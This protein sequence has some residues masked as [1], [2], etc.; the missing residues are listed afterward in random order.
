MSESSQHYANKYIERLAEL[1]QRGEPF[2]SVTLVEAIGSTPQDV[3]AKMLVDQHGLNF[4]T[5]GGGRVEQRALALAA[6]MIQD[7]TPRPRVELVEWNLQRDI[8]M[9]CGGSVRMFFELFNAR[10]WHIVIFG[11]GHVAQSLVRYL[12]PLDCQ[13]T[14]IDSRQEWLERLPIAAN[15]MTICSAQPEDLVAKLRDD[16]FVLCMTMG[17]RTD[18]PILARIFALGRRFPYLG[19]I[20]SLA[21]RKV[22]VR[23][24]CDGGLDTELANQFTCPIGLQV[25][26]N[27]P[28][29]IAISVVA[30]LIQVRDAV[31]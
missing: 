4:G 3:G 22:L 26:S 8:G 7:T 29:E 28:G 1:D 24:L 11:A 5:I 25:G 31:R 27:H 14:C 2:V 12:Q 17:H 15:V 13:V 10:R 18:R 20:G 23:E 21:K 19:V 9:T 16:D 30:Q 6:E